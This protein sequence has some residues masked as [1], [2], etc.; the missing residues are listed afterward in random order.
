MSTVKLNDSWSFELAFIH[1]SALLFAIEQKPARGKSRYIL[2][3]L[4]E[5]PG[6]EAVKR[7]VSLLFSPLFLLFQLSSATTDKLFL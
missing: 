4:K 1:C 2:N 5:K 3:N 7:A 6:A